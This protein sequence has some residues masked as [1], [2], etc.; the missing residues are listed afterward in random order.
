ME[1][2]K[3]G[4]NASLKVG[5]LTRVRVVQLGPSLSIIVGSAEAD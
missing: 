3:L 5:K 2:H 4:G 1:R